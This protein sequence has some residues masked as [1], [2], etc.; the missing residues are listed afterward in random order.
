MISRPASSVQ[1]ATGIGAGS[2]RRA[3]VACLPLLCRLEFEPGFSTAGQSMNTIIHASA[4]A[5]RGAGTD[6]GYS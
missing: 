5:G 4:H 1:T 3:R 2:R 6:I